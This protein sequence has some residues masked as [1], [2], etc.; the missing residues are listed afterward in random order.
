M[1][2]LIPKNKPEHVRKSF[3]STMSLNLKIAAGLI[4]LG[5]IVYLVILLDDMNYGMDLV[6][7]IVEDEIRGG[8]LWFHILVI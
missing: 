5:I 1:N 7:N 4:T 2:N 3:G 6:R 8:S